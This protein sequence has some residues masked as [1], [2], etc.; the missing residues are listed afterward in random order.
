MPQQ[1]A[2][3]LL[4]VPGLLCT[5]DLFAAQASNLGG[6]RTVVIVDHTRSDRVE[7]E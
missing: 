7:R 1:H 2:E 6:D 4:L 5:S 3:P